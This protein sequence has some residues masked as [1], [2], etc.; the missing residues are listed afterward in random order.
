MKHRWKYAWA[1]TVLLVVEPGATARD[2]VNGTGS[3]LVETEHVVAE[4]LLARVV[5]MV[6]EAQSSRAPSSVR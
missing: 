2:T 1:V 3:L 5:G 6:S 4:T